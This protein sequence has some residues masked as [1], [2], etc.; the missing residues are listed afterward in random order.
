MLHN[1]R[2]S[3]GKILKYEVRPSRV[4]CT[5]DAVFLNEFVYFESPSPELLDASNNNT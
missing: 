5:M 1:Q 3:R 2:L 4:K